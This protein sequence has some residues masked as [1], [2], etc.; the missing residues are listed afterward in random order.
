MTDEE[1]LEFNR[2]GFIPGPDET[3]EKYLKRI[4]STKAAY[5]KLGVAAIPSS[6]WEWVEKKI[7]DGFDFVPRSLPAFYSNRSLAPWQGAAAWVERDQILAIQLR[8]AFK[9]G[10]FLKIYSRSEILAHEAVHAAR[11]AF[12]AD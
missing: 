2:T 8:E 10:S 9:K 1:L 6:H 11:S 3:E 7:L 5:L 4:E 12:P